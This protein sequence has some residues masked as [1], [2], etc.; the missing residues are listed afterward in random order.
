M[1]IGELSIKSGFS[2]DTI[3]YYEKIGLIEM[4]DNRT[5]LSRHKN[6]PEQILRQLVAVKIM[7]GFGF[8][9]EETKNIFVLYEEGVIDH[10]RGKKY[11]LRKVNQIENKIQELQKFR[12]RLLEIADE[13]DSNCSIRKIL[14][15]M[16][17]EKHV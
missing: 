13:K 1:R 16:S 7:K 6:Y 12:E 14:E 4:K 3:R 17:Y 2:R 5:H 10:Q 15:E 8:T 9:L 11:L